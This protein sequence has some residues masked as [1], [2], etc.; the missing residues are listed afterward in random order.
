MKKELH[1]PFVVLPES[2]EKIRREIRHFIKEEE[3]AGNITLNNGGGL[4]GFSPEFSQ[5]L[6]KHGWLGMILPK[7]Y[8]GQERSALERF[9]VFEELISSG[10]PN[11]YHWVAER[12][13]G[14]LLMKYGTEEQK[15]K[16]LPRIARGE[17]SVCIGMSEANAG[18]DLANIST[19]AEKKGNIWVINGSKIWTSNAHRAEYI[20]VLC[21]TEKRTE[22]RHAGI[23]KFF[24]DLTTP[25]ITVR[26]IVSMNGRH[27]FNEVFFENVEVG[28]DAIIGEIGKG[29]QQNMDELAFERSGPERYLSTFALLK[30]FTRM[31]GERADPSNRIVLGNLVSRL[32]TLRHMS[33]GVAGLIE[34]G[35]TPNLAAALVKD[36]GTQFE[37]NM[38]EVLRLMIPSKPSLSSNS[39]YEVLLGEALLNSPS[40]TLRGG[41][42]EILRRIIS[43]GLGI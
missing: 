31:L 1:L 21:R 17:L 43:R 13:I 8:G 42:T 23:S 26:P 10:A 15:Q 22:D 38:A 12:Q 36:L 14:P 33:L 32:W 34:K 41:T 20:V 18:S 6:A 3:V 35:E 2:A 11:S 28:E 16:Y 5:K 29:W 9:V 7:K 27:H 40:F 19:R 39:H 25:G 37:K 24:V 4:G 30:E